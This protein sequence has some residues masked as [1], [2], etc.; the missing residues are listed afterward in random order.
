[1]SNID[2]STTAGK[3]EIQ[4]AY[5]NG[6]CILAKAY[7]DGSIIQLDKTREPAWSWNTVQYYIKAQTVE[8]AAESWCKSPCP[9]V[10]D[11]LTLNERLTIGFIKG[12]QWQKENQ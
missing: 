6:E 11:T 4:Q 2:T 7:S 10:W 3:I 5:I 9:D 8:E 12:A 1:M